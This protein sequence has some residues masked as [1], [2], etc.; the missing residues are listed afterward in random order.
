MG[1][2]AWLTPQISEHC[3]KKYP[4]RNLKIEALF[5]RP[6]LASTLTPMLGIVQEWMTSSEVTKRRIWVKKG[7]YKF[8]FSTW[9]LRKIFAPLLI[10]SVNILLLFE[11]KSEYSYDHNHCCPMTLIVNTG[12]I[13][14]SIKKRTWIEGIAKNKRIKT[15]R[16][17]QIISVISLLT[18]L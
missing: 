12:L 17:V 4:L 10:V 8:L 14:S 7:K 13:S 16:E 15:G 18:N 6:G 3:P 11:W 5:N 2:Y 1:I 9:R